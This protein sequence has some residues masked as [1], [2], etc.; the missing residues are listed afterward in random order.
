MYSWTL[1]CRNFAPLICRWAVG[2]CQLPTLSVPTNNCLDLQVRP[3]F[4]ADHCAEFPYQCSFCLESQ[5]WANTCP[6]LYIYQEHWN[7][8]EFGIRVIELVN[9]FLIHTYRQQLQNVP[10]ITLYLRNTK[11]NNHLRYIS[12]KTSL[13]CNYTLLSANVKVLETFL[14]VIL[15]KPLQLF[16]HIL[17]DVSSITNAP[18]LQCWLQLREQ[19]KISCNQVRRVWEVLH[20]CHLDLC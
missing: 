4:Q 17:N 1:S 3:V 18:S 16:R 9:F 12:F 14:E 6:M 2:E 8:N 7:F 20:C 19:V 15:W 10:G 5:W 11:Q 13:L